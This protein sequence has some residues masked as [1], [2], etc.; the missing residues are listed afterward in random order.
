ME[1]ISCHRLTCLCLQQLHRKD[2]WRLHRHTPSTQLQRNQRNEVC[3][4]CCNCTW[5]LNTKRYI[6]AF[7]KSRVR[8]RQRSSDMF[9]SRKVGVQNLIIQNSAF[10]FRK[11]FHMCEMVSSGFTQEDDDVLFET[12]CNIL[13]RWIIKCGLSF[14]C[15]K[16]FLIRLSVLLLCTEY[17][18]EFGVCPSA[19]FK[20]CYTLPKVIYWLILRDTQHNLIVYLYVWQREPTKHST[21]FYRMHSLQK[22][23]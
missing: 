5:L 22:Y 20:S 11:P 8:F 19:L 15:K 16:E 9:P 21:T 1:H 3:H 7:S 13:L 17:V 12:E 23:E 4:F 2:D 18:H 6:S 10:T 14:K